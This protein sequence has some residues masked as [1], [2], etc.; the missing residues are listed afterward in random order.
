MSSILNMSSPQVSIIVPVWN[1]GAYLRPCLESI[2]NQT[3][4]DFEL[5]LVLDC[6]TDGSDVIAEEYAHNDPRIRILKNTRNMHIG[7]NR[8]RGLKEARG[9]YI[10]FVDHDD[11]CAM[12]LLEKLITQ[13]EQQQADI[14]LSP[15]L[16]T[17]RYDPTNSMCLPTL[18]NTRIS[19]TWALQ[20]ALSGGEN[21]KGTF[22]TAVLGVLF[23]RTIIGDSRFVDT[24][25]Q[26][27][28]DLYFLITCLYKSQSVAFVHSFL[29]THIE[30]TNNAGK[31]CHYLGLESRLR[32][33][34]QIYQDITQWDDSDEWLPY[35]STGLVKQ[36]KHLLP[37]RRQWLKRL[38]TSTQ[39]MNIEWIKKALL[40]TKITFYAKIML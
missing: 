5:L 33:M 18:G 34:Q 13:A 10:L 19:R 24:R 2:L 3:F 28:E 17:N 21:P 23:R 39:I 25:V 30:H 15:V 31:D 37:R 26:S 36:I 27:A 8:N 32:T 22:I 11:I 38:R 6:P 16:T 20:E 7:N 9:K 14:V 35:F 12:T 40:E 1:A 4:Q 29:Y